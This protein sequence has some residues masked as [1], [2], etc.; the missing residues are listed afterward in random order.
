MCPSKLHGGGEMEN[1]PA[2]LA[3]AL[4][5]LEASHQHGER[6]SA[7]LAAAQALLNES[8]S[9]IAEAKL[10]KA[11]VQELNNK[12]ADLAQ[13]LAATVANA[14]T[15]DEQA[16]ALVAAAGHPPIELAPSED[17]K[18][19][20]KSWKEQIQGIADPMERGRI[21]AAYMQSLK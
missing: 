21:L 15:A 1:S 8:A 11:Q 3:D 18:P 9:A 17:V 2:T 7:E 16:A 20:A 10:L 12:N 6:L 14:K 13:Q 5:A 4:N 19:V